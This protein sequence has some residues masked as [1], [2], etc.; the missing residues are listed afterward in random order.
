MWEYDIF[1][2]L[3]VHNDVGD[4]ICSPEDTIVVAT[5]GPESNMKNGE[6]RETEEHKDAAYE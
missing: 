4:G 6:Y 3:S 1:G 5:G 2:T